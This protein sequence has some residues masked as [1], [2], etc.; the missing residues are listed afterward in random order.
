[1]DAS[2]EQPPRLNETRT[3]VVPAYNVLVIAERRWRRAERAAPALELRLPARV[4]MRPHEPSGCHDAAPNPGAL[5]LSVARRFG[6]A[7]RGA[8]CA[9][10]SRR[11]AKGSKSAS[12]AFNERRKE[13]PASPPIRNSSYRAM[14]PSIR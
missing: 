3:E 1:M 4:P 13:N 11:S 14:G 12:P 8:R 5:W 7:G 10:E 6:A 9:L 2:F